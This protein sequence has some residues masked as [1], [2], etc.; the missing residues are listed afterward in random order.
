MEI[1]TIAFRFQA[2]ALISWYCSLSVSAH[3]R[4]LVV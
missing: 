3:E 2:V 4:L 1:N